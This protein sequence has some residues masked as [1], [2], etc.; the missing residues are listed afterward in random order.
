M[1]CIAFNFSKW[2]MMDTD[3]AET[4]DLLDGYLNKYLNLVTIQLGEN[5]SDLE[6]FEKDFRFFLE[7]IIK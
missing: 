4:L 3:R 1:C 7:C 2:E 6:T 5:I